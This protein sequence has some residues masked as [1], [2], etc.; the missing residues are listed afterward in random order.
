MRST[1]CGGV[2]TVQMVATYGW[3]FK[4]TPVQLSEF[5]L[6]RF[7]YF[8]IFYFIAPSVEP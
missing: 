5:P 8:L 6:Y 2:F 4:P 1:S 3:A 7:A